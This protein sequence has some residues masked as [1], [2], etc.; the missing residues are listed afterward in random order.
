MNRNT[1]KMWAPAVLAV[2]V[3][4]CG[5]SGSPSSPTTPVGNPPANT[6]FGFV[7]ASMGMTLE[8]LPVWSIR[9]ENSEL[10]V[11]QL[12]FGDSTGHNNPGLHPLR[13]VNT[14]VVMS[15]PADLV[16]YTSAFQKGADDWTAFVGQFKMTLTTAASSY[17]VRVGD[18]GGYP[19]VAQMQFGANGIITGAT[20]TFRSV[21]NITPYT[22]AHEFAH[23]FGVDHFEGNGVMGVKLSDYSNIAYAQPEIDNVAMMLR[24]P[25]GTTFP[26]G[27]SVSSVKDAPRTMV[28]TSTVKCKLEH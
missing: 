11:K 18:T 20:V 3:V 19:A 8:Q 9:G 10:Y 23:V 7:S 24:L 22:V 6:S 28:F 2:A 27:T 25:L 17:S 1:A 12:A 15:V 13:R 5:G 16:D 21:G 14:N 26:A 4:S